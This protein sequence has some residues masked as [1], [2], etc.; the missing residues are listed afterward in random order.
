MATRG[1]PPKYNQQ[2]M[3]SFL[4]SHVEELFEKDEDGKT[5]VAKKSSPVWCQLA[6]SREAALIHKDLNEGKLYCYV[7][8][9]Q[10]NFRSNFIASQD[11][12]ENNIPADDKSL[13]D[14]DN[15]TADSSI[16]VST[17]SVI[18][19]M[20]IP[21]V[22]FGKL[23]N[24]TIYYSKNENEARREYYRFRPFQWEGVINDYYRQKNPQSTCSFKFK[25][26]WLN[27]DYS[28][29]II[30]KCKCGI[31]YEGCILNFLSENV[32]ITNTIVLKKTGEKCG[33]DYLRGEKRKTI[34]QEMVESNRLPAVMEALQ[35]DEVKKRRRNPATLYT[36]RVLS[37]AKSQYV[38]SKHIDK[39]PFRSLQLL[40][41]G[42]YKEYILSLSFRPF[43]V[44]YMV[45][46]QKRNYVKYWRKNGSFAAADA[47]GDIVR[48]FVKLEIESTGPIFLY[49]IV[50]NDEGKQYP[51]IQMLSESHTASTIATWLNT[52]IELGNPVPKKFVCDGSRAFLLASVTSFT[53]FRTVN[54]YV[55]SLY[56]DIKPTCQI[57]IDFAHF[58][59][60][61]AVFLKSSNA[62]L[63]KF[64]MCCIGL[65]VLCSNKEAAEFNLECILFFLLSSKAGYVGR[66]KTKAQERI[67]IINEKLTGVESSIDESI[68]AG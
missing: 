18:T 9:N 57:A 38:R 16:D 46:D 27:N 39:C 2:Q 40:S 54:D 25:N 63:K 37:N 10:G 67:E 32:L 68:D 66:Q 58:M 22:E 50:V 12:D 42:D 45:A 6:Q 30:G 49:E 29:R 48:K 26:H 11:S 41:L 56:D 59:H 17:D 1:R 24:R 33:V 35:A 65:L 53:N 21:Q 7:V 60:K 23:L 62:G 52:W 43:Y 4:Q 15:D 47:T 31:E 8:N 5:V 3:L 64:Y 14:D 34:A 61:F 28:G 19:V 36:S 20:S 51:V 55:N 13:S 44:V